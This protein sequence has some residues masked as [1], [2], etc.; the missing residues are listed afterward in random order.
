VNVLAVGAHPDDIELGCG[1]T[2]L[3]HRRRGDPIT[4]LVMTTGERGP[5]SS[6]SRIKEQEDA[7]E[8]LGA[9]LIW[10]GFPDS[11]VPEGRD[12]IDVIQRALF[13][14]RADVVYTH[15][16][17]D[18]HQDHRA[19]AVASLAACRRLSRI[20][21]YEAPSSQTF[22]PS[23]YVD[24]SG[25]VEQKA[26]LLKA[27]VSQVLKNA[28]VDLDAVAAQARYRGFQARIHQAEAFEVDRFV[29]DMTPAI[30][31]IEALPIDPLLQEVS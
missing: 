27:H 7:A 6:R 28:L 14:A 3:A 17:R 9:N 5:Q 26:A 15:A 18:T 20:L 1:A 19:T 21:M 31:S 24:V 29:W 23:V 12:A 13:T 25:L 22:L 2:L 8:L 10:A 11:G 4:M 30:A 16:P